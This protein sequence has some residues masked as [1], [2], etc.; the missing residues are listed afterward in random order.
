[1]HWIVKLGCEANPSKEE[2]PIRSEFALDGILFSCVGNGQ[3]W[4]NENLCDESSVLL[5]CRLI[6]RWTFDEQFV[7]VE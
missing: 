5:L 3:W 6:L 1:M 7:R 4:I 2:N